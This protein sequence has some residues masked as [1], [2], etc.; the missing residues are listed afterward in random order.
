MDS[1]TF[2]IIACA[3]QNVR[4]KEDQFISFSRSLSSIDI[5]EQARTRWCGSRFES[6]WEKSH[7]KGIYGLGRDIEASGP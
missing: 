6:V 5:A 7:L 1:F 2:L 4:E 3:R